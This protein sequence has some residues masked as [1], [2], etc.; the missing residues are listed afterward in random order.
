[1]IATVV[2]LH[3]AFVAFCFGFALYQPERLGLLPVLVCYADFPAS[4]LAEW[5]RPA[6]ADAVGAHSYRGKLLADAT[7]YALVG[8]AWW[9]LVGLLLRRLIRAATRNV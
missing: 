7:V 5:A 6:L 9:L 3:L 1:M 4:L 2:L 8:S